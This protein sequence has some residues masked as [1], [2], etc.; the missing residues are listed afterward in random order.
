MVLRTTL[1][2]KTHPVGK[3]KPNPFGLYDMHGNVWEWVEDCLQDNYEG[4]PADG[5]AWVADGDCNAVSFAAV[6]GSA[7]R[8][9]SARPTAARASPACGSTASASVSEGRLPLKSLPLYLFTSWVQG[10]ALVDFLSPAANDRQCTT[11]R[12]GP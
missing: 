1:T 8:T 3:K 10:E 4:A 12:R 7:F 2:S 9:S 5:S 11:H 6:P